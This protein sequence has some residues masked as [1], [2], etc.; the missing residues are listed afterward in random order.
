MRLSTSVASLKRRS[1]SS[2]VRRE[3]VRAA[4]DRPD[5]EIVHAFDPGDALELDRARRSRRAGPASS[6]TSLASRSTLTTPITMMA[7]TKSES[8]GSIQA[9]SG[10]RD[11]D[12]AG[13]H[14][15]GSER[16]SH[17]VQSAARRL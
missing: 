6:S 1:S 11:H 15:E 2:D 16:V 4:A 3:R 14:G 10:Q 13:D 9:A 8:A 7:A 5:V 17:N 12:A